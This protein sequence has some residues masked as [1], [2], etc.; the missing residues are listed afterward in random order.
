MDSIFENG[1]VLEIILLL[2]YLSTLFYENF[3]LKLIYNR[4][5]ILRS[6]S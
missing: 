5:E 2:I 4:L 6:D 1:L 3:V